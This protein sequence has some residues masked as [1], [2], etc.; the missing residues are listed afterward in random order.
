ML[1]TNYE[2]VCDV[3][4]SLQ[5]GAA[6]EH[7]HAKSAVEHSHAKC[8]YRFVFVRIQHKHNNGEPLARNWQVK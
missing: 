3:D 5:L 1:M 6:V 2:S 4:K 8:D 7:S